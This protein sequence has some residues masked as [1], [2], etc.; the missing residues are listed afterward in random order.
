MMD[1]LATHLE[2]LERDLLT[3]GTRR[4][5]DRVEA[6]LAPEFREFGSSGRS[7]DRDRIVAELLTETSSSFELF[8]FRCETLTAAVALVTYRTE[9][10]AISGDDSMV[11]AL[12]SSIWV[13]RCGCWQMV[14]HQGTPLADPLA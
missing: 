7:Y 3:E 9:R 4:S 12:R 1:T 11:R 8:D 14:F 10:H 5:R 2:A 13:E 6:L